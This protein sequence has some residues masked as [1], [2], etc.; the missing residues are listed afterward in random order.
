MNRELSFGEWLNA[1]RPSLPQPVKLV[2]TAGF[3]VFVGL[4]TGLWL[5]HTDPPVT[6]VVGTPTGVSINGGHT[7][8]DRAF[9][10]KLV[11]ELNELP[12][13]PVGVTCATF[14]AVP[15]DDLRFDYDDG[16][17]LTVIV[18]TACGVT[19]AAAA[20]DPHILARGDAALVD[21]LRNWPIAP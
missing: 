7:V 13:Y 20:Y 14:V 5:K 1:P 10:A 19:T 21:E 16:D 8:R 3:L 9:I 6:M 15:Q 17:R 4:G 2:L 12:P 18:K 11:H